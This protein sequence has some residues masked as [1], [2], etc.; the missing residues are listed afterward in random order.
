MP[1]GVRRAIFC[2]PSQRCATAS[3]RKRSA[4]AIAQVVGTGVPRSQPVNGASP[5]TCPALPDLCDGAL[6][7]LAG[8]KS[9]LWEAIPRSF[10]GRIS[11]SCKCLP[12]S[13]SAGACL[14][15]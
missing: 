12:F 7:M 8:A 4:S 5:V 13:A 14:G 11:M 10:R 6:R 3:S 2:T 9:F 15:L 1:P